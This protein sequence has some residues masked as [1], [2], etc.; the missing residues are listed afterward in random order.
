MTNLDNVKS[1]IIRSWIFPLNLTYIS[2]KSGVQLSESTVRG[3]SVV[4]SGSS[5]FSSSCPRDRSKL[6]YTYTHTHTHTSQTNKQHIYA[7]IN[8][9]R[10]CSKHACVTAFKH[11]NEIKNPEKRGNVTW[12][13][14]AGCSQA[15]LGDCLLSQAN[16][17]EFVFW[18]LGLGW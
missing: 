12:N 8:S 3:L 5:P 11:E 18:G 7:S 10:S 6:L 4:F 1:S 14:S 15:V 16:M 9:I 2:V 13:A 17:Y